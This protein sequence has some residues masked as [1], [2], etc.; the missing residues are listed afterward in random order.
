M[1]DLI[2]STLRFSWAMS[3]FGVQQLE[4]MVEDA[5]HQ[6]SKTI[7]AFESVSKTAEEEIGGVVRDAYKSGERL[8]SRMVDMILG[9]ASGRPEPTGS[10][11]PIG[12]G[13]IQQPTTD[14][15]KTTEQTPPVNSGRLNTT[16]FVVLGEGLAAGMG[17]FTLTEETQR[18]SFP[19]QMDRQMQTDFT[20]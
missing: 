4:N 17:D 14:S 20:Q 6:D 10:T 15:A 11:T 12:A 7:T 13:P 3:L 16:T 2:K 5:S 19:A 1:R 8:Q 9:A 18:E